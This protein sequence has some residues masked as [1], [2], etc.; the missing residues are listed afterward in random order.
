MATALGPVVCAG[1]HDHQVGRAGLGEQRLEPLTGEGVGPVR[2]RVL[3]SDGVPTGEHA[4][5]QDDVA[6]RVGDV[7]ALGGRPGHQVDDVRQRRGQQH[8]Q[9]AVEQVRSMTVRGPGLERSRG[10]RH[11]RSLGAPSA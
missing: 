11:T 1:V 3:V 8:I 2:Q 10:Q 7:H 4:R 5:A 9:G 6:P